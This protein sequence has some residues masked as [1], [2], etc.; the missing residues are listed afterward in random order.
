[1]INTPTTTAMGSSA[2]RH[3]TGA[4]VS[5]CYAVHLTIIAAAAGNK[6]VRFPA[7]CMGGGTTDDR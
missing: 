6:D 2:V 7:D 3:Y 5:N 4:L 1:M